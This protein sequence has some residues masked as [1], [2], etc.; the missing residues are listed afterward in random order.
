MLRRKDSSGE[1]GEESSREVCLVLRD[2]QEGG[3]QVSI[4]SGWGDL[5]WDGWICVE[6]FASCV[7]RWVSRISDLVIGNWLVWLDYLRG[8]GWCSSLGERRRGRRFVVC[9]QDDPEED[10]STL[11]LIQ[12]RARSTFLSVGEEEKS[13]LVWRI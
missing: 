13:A 2:K 11:R 8:I 7:L 3:W 9:L 6:S 12:R 5:I 4:H 10:S 1:E